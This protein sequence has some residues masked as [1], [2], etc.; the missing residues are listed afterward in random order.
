MAQWITLLTFIHSAQAH[1][2]KTKLESEGIEVFLKNE[3]I[4]QLAPHHTE[5]GG[6]I[7]LQVLEKDAEA[8]VRLLKEN[9]YIK[10]ERQGFRKSALIKGIDLFT[11][12]I[13]GFRNIPLQLRL[14][15]AVAVLLVVVTLVVAMVTLPSNA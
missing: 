6:S 2:I 15:F 10:E 5:P 8:A 11:A 3:L 13:P 7:K 4:T 9:G 1:L 14:V 12:K